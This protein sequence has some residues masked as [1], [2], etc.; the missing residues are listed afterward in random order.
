[1]ASMNL[2]VDCSTGESRLVPLDPQEQ[3]FKDR[4]EAEAAQRAAGDE[5]ASAARA[6]ALEELKAKARA[7]AT[8]DA[9]LVARVLGVD[10]R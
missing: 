8:V 6:N 9:K 7:N 3:A 4:V 10:I 2:V 5:A 1:M